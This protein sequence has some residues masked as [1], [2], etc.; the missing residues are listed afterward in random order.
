[1]SFELSKGAKNLK[2]KIQK[3]PQIILCIDG[4][5][6][7]FGT[8]EILRFPTFDEDP[9]LLFDDGLYFDTPIRDSNGRD[10]I[11]LD[12]TTS[13]LQQQIITEKGGSGSVPTFKVALINKN[14]E[15][16][17]YFKTINNVDLIGRDA[18]I[19]LGFKGGVFPD[20]FIN[21]FNG[22]VD[23]FQVSHGRYDLN[24]A[25]PDQKRRQ[26]IL[27][28]VTT[29]TTAAIDNSQITIPVNRTS[30]WILP[31]LEQEENFKAYIRIDDEI[32]KVNEDVTSTQFNDVLRNQ[33]GTAVSEH[34]DESDVESFYRIEGK[35]IDLI[36]KL[37]LSGGE[38]FYQEDVE[39]DRFIQLSTGDNI[40]N[41]IFFQEDI[42]F[43]YNVKVGDKVT[44]TG[45]ANAENNFVE[46]TIN[47]IIKSF[48]GS[49]ITV[50]G[51]GLVLET[52]SNAVIKFKSQFNTMPTGFGL[53]PKNIDLD[54]IFET[55]NI[56]GVLP[57]VDFYIDDALEGRE[58]IE[59]EILKP[60]GLYSLSRKGRFSIKATLPPLVTGESA[61]IDENNITN[62]DKIKIGRN[63]TKDF[64]NTVV[65]KIEKRAV[66]G[67]FRQGLIVANED[68]FNRFKI[69]RQL[70][71]EAQAFRDEI[72][73]VNS[74]QNQ[75]ERIID[76]YKFAPQTIK[77]LQVFFKDGYTIEAGDTI[78]FGSDN[79]QL[80]NTEE[81]TDNFKPQLFEVSN[82]RMNVKTGQIVLDLIN[83]AFGLD[84]RYGVIS[85]ASIVQSKTSDKTLRLNKSFGNTG[86]ESLKY[87]NLVNSPMVIRDQNFTKEQLVTISQ[88]GPNDDEITFKEDISILIEDGDVLEI[89]DYNRASDIQK[90]IYVF[91]DPKEDVTAVTDASNIEADTSAM[92]IGC[93]IRVHNEDY[94]NLSQTVTISNIIGNNIE[95]EEPLNYVPAVNDLIDIIGFVDD[96]GDGY[97]HV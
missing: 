14:K 89:P 16:N 94:S 76:K 79:M 15:L 84:F 77:G 47:S 64:Y 20:D 80:P 78:V 73:T 18:L 83:S 24:I 44:V 28:K 68:S 45:A 52:D 6:L 97:A 43:N 81:G 5:P 48:D 71:I 63:T 62:I 72:A 66:D 26:K 54:G 82:K 34:D 85:P 4:V 9:L 95:L 13:Q 1:M 10:Y 59:T 74:L 57:D 87:S 42:V 93:K 41:A 60:L 23:S 75:A 7:K 86:N 40:Q 65:Y 92:F 56:V 39:I 51:G 36:L 17:Q 38:E 19:F 46:R 3:T 12:G 8:A 29:K 27:N 53:K 69:T 32:I 22:Y 37:L 67:R 35:P 55:E 88:V 31:T 61:F 70:L 96:S 21:I 25:H 58:I 2:E 50:D 33:L 30:A 90:A 91:L 49:Y 11:S